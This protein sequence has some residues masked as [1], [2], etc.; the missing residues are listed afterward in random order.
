MTYTIEYYTL[1]GGTRRVKVNAETRDEAIDK[2]QA[3]YEDIDQ[4]ISVTAYAA[5][6]EAVK[7]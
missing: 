2:A 6:N 5:D 3:V 7:Q 4:F 1:S